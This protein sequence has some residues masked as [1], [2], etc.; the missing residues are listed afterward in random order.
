MSKWNAG[1]T[2]VELLVTLAIVVIVT[3][4]LVKMFSSMAIGHTSRITSADLQQSV[5]AVLDLM[6]RELRMAG[7]SSIRPGGFGIINA[8]DGKLTFSV[9]WNNDGYLTES[10]GANPDIR[11]ESDSISYHFDA[12]RHRLVRVTAVGPPVNRTNQSSAVRGT[13]CGLLALNSPILT[14]WVLKLDE[15]KI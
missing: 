15:L 9:D 3:G 1:F 5:R 10:H 12:A 4:S 6:G 11:E 13:R 7:F 2:L 8:E 14:G